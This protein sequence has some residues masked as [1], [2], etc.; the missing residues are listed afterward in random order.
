MVKMKISVSSYSFRQYIRAGKMTQFDCVAKA[1]ELGFDAIEF[2][3]LDGKT[4]EEQKENAKKLKEEADRLGMEINAYTIAANLYQDTREKMDA[5]VERLKG[6]LEVAAIL[7]AGVLRHDVCHS[8]GKTGNARSFDLMLPTIAEN[9]RRVSE[10]AV[11]LGIKTCSENH[12]MIAQDS[13]RVER[14]FNAVNHDNFGLL[15]DMGN[16]LCVDENPVT[17]VSRVAPYAI[18]AHAKDM[19]VRERPFDGYRMITRGGN[20]LMCTAVGEGDVPIEQCLRI[21]KK[22]GYEGYLSIEFEGREDC[23]EGIAKGLKN[24][25][26]YVA[27]VWG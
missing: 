13:D 4:L 7:G 3:D 1:K 22:A 6:Q 5:E 9:A 11:T 18:H 19:L 24:L 21:L 14:L 25:K 17:A 10:Y 23:I 12:G 20:Y 27:E 8:L 16:F 26:K 15:V 2:I